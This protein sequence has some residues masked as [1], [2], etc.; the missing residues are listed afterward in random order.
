[1]NTVTLEDAEKAL[2]EARAQL[3]RAA[4]AADDAVKRDAWRQAEI[5]LARAARIVGFLATPPAEP[6]GLPMNLPT[7]TVRG[8]L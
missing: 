7:A 5:R 2:R 1:M 4:A 8:L 3:D 6:W